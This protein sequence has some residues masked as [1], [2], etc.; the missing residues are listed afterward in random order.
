MDSIV[1]GE[2][3]QRKLLAQVDYYFSRQNLASDSFL[4]SQMNAELFVP[5]G[6]IAS[7]AKVRE[8]SLDNLGFLVETMKLS[9]A[10][11]VDEQGQRARPNFKL[12][13]TTLMLRNIPSDATLEAVRA[14]LANVN[15]QTV[16]ADIGDNWFVTLASES[17]AIAALGQLHG[18]L[19][20]GRTVAARLKSESLLKQ[21]A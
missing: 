17:E 21:Y 4:V 5:I 6:L 20:E 10:I 2:E 3:R 9:S 7:F 12:E 19:Y 8:L 11:V 14:F 16:R 1:D 15:A 18:A 13:R